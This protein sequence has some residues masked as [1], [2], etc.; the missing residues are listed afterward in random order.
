V[1]RPLVET[2]ADALRAARLLLGIVRK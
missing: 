2:I 1:D